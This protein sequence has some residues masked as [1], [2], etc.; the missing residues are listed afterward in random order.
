[1]LGI[2]MLAI[3]AISFNKP[4]ETFIRDHVRIIA[5]GHA[6]LVCRDGRN[7]DQL[8][9]PTIANVGAWR[10]PVGLRERA[11]EKV[12]KHWRKYVSPQMS[13]ADRQR[14][15]SFLRRHN[16]RVL[17][18]EFLPIGVLFPRAC[19]EA[20]VALYVHAHGFDAS[21]L[22]RNRLNEADG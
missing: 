3:A 14:V 4:S 7:A 21:E 9:C 18:A 10:P 15:V 8:G 20:G 13:R 6:V 1:M 19:E 11:I 12:R 22:V 5:P 17:L 2:K 16:V